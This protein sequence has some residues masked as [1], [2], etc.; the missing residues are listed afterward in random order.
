MASLCWCFLSNALFLAACSRQVCSVN[1]LS[2]NFVLAR[3]TKLTEHLSVIVVSDRFCRRYSFHCHRVS[4]VANFEHLSFLLTT[5]LPKHKLCSSH[6]SVA[7][8]LFWNLPQCAVLQQRHALGEHQFIK[9]FH[10]C[11]NRFLNAGVLHKRSVKKSAHKKVHNHEPF[12][13]NDT[14]NKRVPKNWFTNLL[15]TTDVLGQKVP[16]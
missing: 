12:V 3:T 15:A 6:H 1:M 7:A 16:E 9:L 5:D 13:K 10:K 8:I 2:N 14:A 4:H 11:Q